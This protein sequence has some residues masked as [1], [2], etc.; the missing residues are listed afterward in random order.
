MEKDPQRLSRLLDGYFKGTCSKKELNEL[1]AWI[2]MGDKDEA[3]LDRL[4][5]EWDKTGNGEVLPEPDWGG[6]LHGIVSDPGTTRRQAAGSWKW[7]AAVAAVLV[8]FGSVIYAVYQQ[9]FPGKRQQA[10]AD[11]HVQRIVPGGN[12]A[13]LTLADGAT[14]VLDSAANGILARQGGTA[15]QKTRDGIL[16]YTAGAGG[17]NRAPAAMNMIRTPRGGQYQISL[18]DG[19]RVWLNAESSLKFPTSFAGSER[20]VELS[21]EAYFEVARNEAMPFLVNSGRQTVRVLGTR[22]NIN[23]YHNERVIKTTLLEGSVEVTGTRSGKRHI[24]TPGQL[25]TTGGTGEITVEEGYP[26][27][28]IAWK[29]GKF[30][31]NRESIE[32]IMRKIARWYDTEIIYQTD[33]KNIHFTGSV[34]RFAE[35]T[36]VLRKLELTGSVHFKIEERRIIVMP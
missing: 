32:S 24:L 18:P 3:I 13:V 1:F 12:K 8:L 23:A 35:V 30:M 31:F 26:E 33:M 22:F 15:I 20:R 21:G 16:S 10:L 27:Q 28:A 25:A 14:I 29:N 2:R 5:Q 7:V 36:D 11:A 4:R 9:R 19:T 6:M 17:R 34:S